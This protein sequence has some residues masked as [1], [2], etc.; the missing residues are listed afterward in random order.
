[1]DDQYDFNG[2]FT[3]PD[4]ASN[5]RAKR[6]RMV[7]SLIAGSPAIGLQEIQNALAG[8]RGEFALDLSASSV[9]KYLATAVEQGWIVREG[10]TKGARYRPTP[11]FSH[12]FAIQALRRDSKQRPKIG[13]QIEFLESYE[14]NRTFYLP[15]AARQALN[16][17]CPP[18]RISLS[19]QKFA[20]HMRR[21]LADISRYSSGFEGVRASLL[22]T[23]ALLENGIANDNLSPRDAAILR[24]HYN[25]IHGIVNNT[26]FPP[27]P[28]DVAISTWDI[29][30]IH[31]QLSDGLL[32]NPRMQGRLR[33][34]PIAEI[35]GSSYVPLGVEAAIQHA[36]DK[37][38]EK[39]IE[40]KDPY[41]QA[42]FLTVHIPYL[43]PFEDCNKRT[44]RVVCN[45]PLLRQGVLPVSWVEVNQRD[46]ADSLICVY[47]HCS[48][49]GIAQVFT[50]ACRRSVESFDLLTLERNPSQVEITYSRQIK[51]MVVNAVK[52]D[53]RT[54]PTDIDPMHLEAVLDYVDTTLKNLVDNEMIAAPYF[55]DR[56]T[57]NTWRMKEIA[58][59]DS[60]DETDSS[61]DV[62]RG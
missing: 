5:D 37:M 38:V 42:L 31:A 26:S 29:R 6:V 28:T 24:N 40:I 4:S 55:I 20:Q 30:M 35:R 49:Y 36:F 33:Y 1:M 7:A 50:E 17:A 62:P 10:N 57:V 21:F 25:A 34:E 61:A 46:Y 14:P 53:D 13:Y 8:D 19:D 54:P 16:K 47:E 39:A 44:A 9:T 23:I 11:A 15:E 3:D 12:W 51:Q 18:G 60:S 59:L 27:K 56:K 58:K 48:T 41:E 22:D 52:Y 45:I 2:R 43:Q 32:T